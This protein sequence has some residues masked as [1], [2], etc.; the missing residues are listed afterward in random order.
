MTLCEARVKYV[1]EVH[2]VQEA[3]LL[4]DA[5]AT[6]WHR[7]A[8]AA[9]LMLA[10]RDGQARLMLSACEGR[11]RGVKFR[12]LSVSLAVHDI[13]ADEPAAWLLVHAFNSLRLFAWI[14]RAMFA[15]PYYP[16]Q[17]RVRA[18]CPAM[19][20]VDDGAGRLNAVMGAVGGS[21]GADPRPALRSGIEGFEGWIY[22]PPRGRL[23]PGRGKRFYARI[24]GPTQA[25]A[26]NSQLDQVATVASPRSPVFAW[27]KDSSF[28][29]V[30]WQ[31][32]PDA[33][34]AKSA[35]LRWSVP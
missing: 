13:V 2:H 25:Y 14:E 21:S 33:S 7:Q 23:E 16:G 26:F 3:S 1:A 24:S 15:T 10:E 8:E 12:E 17:I 18:A 5:E 28:T 11:F 9:G 19:A 34:H 35:T 31:L 20:E 27:L 22:L 32:R 30:E 4:G 29:G 6:L